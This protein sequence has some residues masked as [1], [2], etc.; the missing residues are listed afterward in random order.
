MIDVS[1]EN[2]IRAYLSLIVD[3]DIAVSDSRYREAAADIIDNPNNDLSSSYLAFDEDFYLSQRGSRRDRSLTALRDFFQNGYRFG[4]SPHPLFDIDYI[5]TVYRQETLAH[6]A[7]SAS[8]HNTVPNPLVLIFGDS[9]NVYSPNALFDITNYSNSVAKA[10]L[11]GI[12]DL[13]HLHPVIHYLRYWR[14]LHNVEALRISD[15]FDPIF[16]DISSSR[17]DASLTDPLTHYMRSSSADRNDCNPKFHGQFYSRNYG[18]DNIDPVTHF[19]RFGAERGFAP[20][21]FAYEE[22]GLNSTV[23]PPAVLRK[24]LLDY[25]KI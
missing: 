8:E 19:I 21:P 7:K 6:K 20:N 2:S 5:N 16:Y 4:L 1:V 22:L 15:F 18:L 9:F 11:P 14:A 23:V 25:T 24:L 13:E 3:R 10:N 17:R 12:E